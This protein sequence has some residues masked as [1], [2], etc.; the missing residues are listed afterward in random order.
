MFPGVHQAQ[1][2]QQRCWLAQ[3]QAEDQRLQTGDKGPEHQCLQHLQRAEEQKLE[4]GKAEE[5][6]EDSEPRAFR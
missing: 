3:E 4:Q 2:V 5:Q 6:K 1:V